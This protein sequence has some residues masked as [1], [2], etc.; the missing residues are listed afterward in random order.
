MLCRYALETTES[1]AASEKWLAVALED[2]VK[3]SLELPEPTST[4]ATL[5]QIA[6]NT[7]KWEASA[8]TTDAAAADA[9]GMRC[10]SVGE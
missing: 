3:S 1:T 9:E 7:S 10:G 5:L 4:L 6:S 2:D 8:A